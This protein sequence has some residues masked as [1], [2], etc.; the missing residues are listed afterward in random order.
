MNPTDEHEGLQV[1]TVG[2]LLPRNTGCDN[3]QGSCTFDASQLATGGML[4]GLGV[5]GVEGMGAGPP[6]A[7]EQNYSQGPEEMV[8]PTPSNMHITPESSSISPLGSSSAVSSGSSGQKLRVRRSTFVPGWA[9]PPRVLLVDDDAVSRRLS[10]KFLQV[11]GCTT[12]VAV[13]G[14]A[15]VNQMNLERYDLVLMVS[16]I[17]FFSYIRFLSFRLGFLVK[18]LTV[19]FFFFSNR[20][21]SCLSWT[22][23]RRRTLF[24]NSTRVRPS[25][26]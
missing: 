4:G 1:Y 10:S 14:V 19:F 11:F 23:C 6:N 17:P 24:A 13:D 3:T 5:G 12:D 18:V 9:V 20:T 26:R 21:S 2:H 15:A 7:S 8:Q 16:L 25:S 22:V